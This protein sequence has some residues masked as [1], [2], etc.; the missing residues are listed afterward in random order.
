IITPFIPA[1]SEHSFN[2]YT[3]RI[4]EKR[5]VVLTRLKE[6]GIACAIY[7]PLCLHL[8]EVHNDLGYKIG[9][10]PVAEKIQTEVLSL[11]MYPELEK[12]EIEEIVKIVKSQI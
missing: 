8:Q 12:E 10:F 11:P 2:Y 7:Y 9:D 6:N 4:K 3:I 1:Y 5:D